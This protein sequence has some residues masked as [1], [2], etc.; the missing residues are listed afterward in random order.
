M[1]LKK[2]CKV[3]LLVGRLRTV[4]LVGRFKEPANLRSYNLFS[5]SGS[6]PEV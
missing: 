2:I 1:D 5:N 4:R 6:K 3:E